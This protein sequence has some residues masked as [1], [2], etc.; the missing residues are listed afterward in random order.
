[1]LIYVKQRVIRLIIADLNIQKVYNEVGVKRQQ[2]SSVYH[3][4]EL[5]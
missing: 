4:H 2:C 1:M 3:V 5:W